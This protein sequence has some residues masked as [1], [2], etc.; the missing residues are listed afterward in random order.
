M[1]KIFNEIGSDLQKWIEAQKIFFVATS[2]LSENGHIN[3][4]PKG[5]DSFR[6][7]EPD[8]VAYQDLTGSGIETLAHIQENKRIVIMFTAFEGP[9]KIVRLHG[10]GEIITPEHDD[11]EGLS[12]LFPKH[13]G[14]RAYIRITL[15]RISDSC[16][17]AVPVYKFKNH[18]DVLDKWSDAKGAEELKIYR[19]AKNA[20]SIDGLKGLA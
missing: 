2:P 7:L 19:Q 14:V 8:I 4:S 1:G 15:T 9:P 12:E 16:G 5:L 17:Y 11:F 10:Q 3:C 18:R 20:T 13:I 6:I